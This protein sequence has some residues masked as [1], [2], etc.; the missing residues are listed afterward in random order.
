M[1]DV[2][3]P[4][5]P[6]HTWRDFLIHIA[7]IVV[8]LLI[9]IGLEQTVEAIHHHHQRV[10]LE[11]DL[12]TEAE[13]NVYII[14]NDLHLAVP[15]QAWFASVIATARDAQPANG[16]VTFVV[17]AF[18]ES[19]RHSSGD[20]YSTVP[21]H[22]VWAVAQATGTVDLLPKQQA[23]IYNRL[24]FEAAEAIRIEGLNDVNSLSLGGVLRTLKID[25]RPGSTVRLTPA[26]RDEFVRATTQFL[27]L[28][29]WYALRLAFW[30][31]A[32]EAV[33]HNVTSIQQM[34]SY[35]QKASA[36]VLEP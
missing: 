4:T 1:L 2:H 14:D 20:K 10:Q 25:L 26:Q 11:E 29:H 23:Q 30:Q 28:D 16:V 13:L 9:A 18:P 32:S 22:G 34:M 12:R 27:E 17:P 31:G 8:G 15:E 19:L 5:H 6:T 35:V 36:Q 7:T 3:P 24:D 21:S 33:L